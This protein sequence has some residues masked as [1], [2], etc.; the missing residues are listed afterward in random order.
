[1]EPLA[2]RRCFLGVPGYKVGLGSFSVGIQ[3]ADAK[4]LLLEPLMPP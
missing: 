1:M 4:G 2:S 3:G